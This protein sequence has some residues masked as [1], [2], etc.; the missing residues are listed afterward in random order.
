[1]I[2]DDEMILETR[3]FIG[4][5]R[6]Y[7]GTHEVN[8]GSPIKP[9]DTTQQARELIDRIFDLELKKEALLKAQKQ[10]QVRVEA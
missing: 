5:Q 9:E 3:P 6:T 2:P 10:Y 7:Q 4:C 1:V 8:F